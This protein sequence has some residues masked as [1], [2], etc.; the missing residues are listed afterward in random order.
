MGSNHSYKGQNCFDAYLILGVEYIAPQNS[1]CK[2]ESTW[3]LL[4]EEMRHLR[5]QYASDY[6]LV[7]GDFN[8]YNGVV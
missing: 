8:A 1:S 7:A 3:D 6:F 5:C 2:N 4:E